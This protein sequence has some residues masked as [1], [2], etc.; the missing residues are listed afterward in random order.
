MHKNE[1]DITI[2]KMHTQ[3][4]MKHRTSTYPVP[5]WY[6]SK[7]FYANN[8]T[9]GSVVC[10]IKLPKPY[11]FFKLVFWFY[12]GQNEYYILPNVSLKKDLR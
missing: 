6:E 1:T 3:H 11:F 8:S 4:T 7:L 5:L 12:F 10:E 2:T 9:Y